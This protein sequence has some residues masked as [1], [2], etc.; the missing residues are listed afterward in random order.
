MKQRKRTRMSG[1]VSH[2]MP[3]GKSYSTPESRCRAKLHRFSKLVEEGYKL[4]GAEKEDY[5]VVM[6]LGKPLKLTI[7]EYDKYYKVAFN[8]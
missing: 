2:T 1:L 6:I 8:V 5:K 3:T 4:I 7:E